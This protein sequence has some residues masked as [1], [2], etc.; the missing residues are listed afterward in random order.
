MILLVVMSLIKNNQVIFLGL[1]VFLVLGLFV[2]ISSFVG[3]KN[4]LLNTIS[5]NN[6]E[7]IDSFDVYVQDQTTFPFDIY[8]HTIVNTTS[9]TADVPIY[10]DYIIVSDSS[11]AI[12]GMAIDI[13]S[14]DRFFQSLI[15]SVDGNNISLFSPIDSVFSVGDIVDFGDWDFSTAD[16]SVDPVSFYVKIPNSVSYDFYTMTM[17]IEDNIVMYDS[18]FGSLPSLTNGFIARAVDGNSKTFFI[19]T[20]NAG[21][22][23]NGFTI[24]YDAKVPSGTYSMNA[25][26]NIREVNGVALR[27]NGEEDEYVEFIVRDDLTDLNKMAI[28]VHGHEVMD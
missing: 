15:K 7:D 14:D 5:D 27:L 13:V 12:P 9:I 26:K 8:A 6:I 16:G 21:F 4:D 23:E 19:I 3:F 10:S 11:G 25:V 18:T 22:R 24:V 1:I 20:N 2:L 17:S 28:A